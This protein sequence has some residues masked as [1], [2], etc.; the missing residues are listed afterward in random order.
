MKIPKKINKLRNR[1]NAQ[2]EA[3]F[4]WIF[5]LIVGGL[6]LAFFTVIVLKQK[7]ASETKL[8]GKI[9]KQLNTIL[10]GA[11]ISPG[12]AQ[13]IPIPKTAIRFTCNDYYIGSASQRL[14]SRV[15]FAHS[16][17][18]GTKLVTWA[19]D[20]NMPFKIANFLYIS[21]PSVRY[22]FVYDP[23]ANKVIASKYYSKMPA[24]FTKELVDTNTYAALKDMKHDHVRFIFFT[25][26]I[27]PSTPQALSKVEMS[28]L[29]VLITTASAADTVNFIKIDGTALNPSLN[30]IQFTTSEALFGAVISDSEDTYKCLMLRAFKRL[31][32]VAQI[33]Q[34][35]FNLL[36]PTFTGTNCE[37][38]YKN[39]AYFKRLISDTNAVVLSEVKQLNIESTKASLK[40]ENAKL[41]LNSCPLFY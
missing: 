5:I 23:P 1:R 3:Q 15:V 29:Q 35:K 31:N 36:A 22:V 28:G 9:T 34:K 26:A 18:K 17:I 13:V 37:G 32:I 11:G 19:L 21:S 40:A 25:S 24:K 33:Y 7:S 16:D 8:S 41:Q 27:P 6:I 12:T 4:N 10:V 39:N 38:F 30:K 2:V 14:G 20:W